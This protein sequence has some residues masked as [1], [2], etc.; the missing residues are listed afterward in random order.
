MPLLKKILLLHY[1][2]FYKLGTRRLRLLLFSSPSFQEFRDELRDLPLGPG[3]SVQRLSSIA[4][5]LFDK[6]KPNLNYQTPIKKG[7]GII[8]N[9]RGKMS[10]L[11]A[12]LQV[13]D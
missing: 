10:K 2:I 4:Q 1:C 8:N 6:E 7:T 9:F 3:G 5:F 11:F 13:G 12:P